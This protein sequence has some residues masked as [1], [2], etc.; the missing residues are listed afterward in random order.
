MAGGS[1]DAEAGAAV[2][3]GDEDGE[4]AAFGEGGD[5]LRGV[6]AGFVELAPVFGGEAGAEFADF[7]A[8]LGV[9]VALGEGDVHGVSYS[10]EG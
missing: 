3:F 5:E 10:W 4:V 8:D 7:L 6:G 1:R 2:L 9:V